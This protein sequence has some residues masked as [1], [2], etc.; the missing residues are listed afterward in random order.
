METLLHDYVFSSRDGA[1]RQS[2]TQ[3]AQTLTQLLGQLL[4]VPELVQAI[5]K[6]RIFEMVNEIFRNSGTGFDLKIEI[7][8]GEEGDLPGEDEQTGARLDKIEEFLVS[9]VAELQ[10]KGALPPPAEQAAEQGQLQQGAAPPPQGVQPA[11]KVAQGASLTMP[12][13]TPNA[14]TEI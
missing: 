14:P 7:E 13:R 8:D 12:E 1:E 3:V 11:P 4:G 10:E 2:N 9:L 5:G 6:E